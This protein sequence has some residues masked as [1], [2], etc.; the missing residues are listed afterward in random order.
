MFRG[1]NFPFACEHYRALCLG[2]EL[3]KHARDR[4]IVMFG[5]IGDRMTDILKNHPHGQQ[6]V[7]ACRNRYGGKIRDLRKRPRKR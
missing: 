5:V 7:D 6:H 4:Q 3:A 1:W 2:P